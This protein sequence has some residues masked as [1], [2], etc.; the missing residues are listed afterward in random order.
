MHVSVWAW[1]FFQCRLTLFIKEHFNRC[2]SVAHPI[3]VGC[4]FSLCETQ[5]ELSEAKR[6][7]NKH[8]DA[9]AMRSQVYSYVRRK[10]NLTN[11]KICKFIQLQ[12][13]QVPVFPCNNTFVDHAW[14]RPHG[15]V[16]A[17]VYSDA[18]ADIYR[19]CASTP[20]FFL[21]CLW[22]LKSVCAPVGVSVCAYLPL[23]FYPPQCAPFI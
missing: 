12:N 8:S 23:P 10:T 21:Q 5:Y 19:L 17:V 14:C 15:S 2:I 4:C 3:I 22:T 13:D 20:E 16:R 1:V 18:P 7:K 6:K 9:T 11:R